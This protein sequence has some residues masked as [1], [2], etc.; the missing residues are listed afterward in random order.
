[1]DG[2]PI[3][4]YLDSVYGYCYFPRMG[5]D[6]VVTMDSKGK[7]DHTRIIRNYVYVWQNDATRTDAKVSLTL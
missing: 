5:I 7:L 6:P 2:R 1:M 3:Q 4:R